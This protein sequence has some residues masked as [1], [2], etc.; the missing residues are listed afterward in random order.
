MLRNIQTLDAIRQ[1]CASGVPLSA[2]LRNWLAQSL[3]RYLEQDCESLNEAFGVVQGHG[4][5]PWWRERAIRERDAELR[6]LFHNFFADHPLSSRARAIA[7][8]SRRYAATCWTRDRLRDAMPAHYWATPKEHLWRAFK[9]GAK[10]PISERHL[11]T[12]LGD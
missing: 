7:E 12:L 2:N 10:M 5:V 6:A 9:S 8:L 1:S 4:G 3:S 11:R